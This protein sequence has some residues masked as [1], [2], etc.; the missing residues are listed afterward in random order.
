MEY[1]VPRSH[2]WDAVETIQ[3]EYGATWYTRRPPVASVILVFVLQKW[4]SLS[5]VHRGQSRHRGFKDLF[6]EDHK[7]S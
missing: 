7:E 3:Q 6:T 5:V 4:I 1:T 2:L